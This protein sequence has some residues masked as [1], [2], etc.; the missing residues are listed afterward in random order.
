[1]PKAGAEGSY[2][3]TPTFRSVFNFLNRAL[4]TSLQNNLIVI[5]QFASALLQLHGNAKNSSTTGGL[6]FFR[7]LFL[8]KA[9]EALKSM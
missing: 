2:E 3:K 4:P 9:K 5:L 8:N 7:S 6:H 1:V